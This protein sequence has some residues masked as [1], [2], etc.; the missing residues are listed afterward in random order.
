MNRST[1]L[2]LALALIAGGLG[3]WLGQRSQPIPLT[4]DPLTVETIAIGQRLPETRLPDLDGVEREIGE[5]AGKLTVINFWASW[6]PPC[7]EEMP[8]LAA[9]HEAHEDAQVLTIALDQPEL[10]RAFLDELGVDLPAL[11]AVP[12]PQ[13]LSVRLGNSRGVLPYTVVVDADWKLRER[14]L[15]KVDRP[16]LEAWRARHL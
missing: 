11:V 16:M 9:F 6:C 4:H 8:I 10:A 2:V 3:L 5:W 13:D 15:G 1:L 12:G 14:H 7:I